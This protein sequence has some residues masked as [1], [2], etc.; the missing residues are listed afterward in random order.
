MSRHII[1]HTSRPHRRMSSRGRFTAPG[2]L[3]AAGLLAGIAVIGIPLESAQAS[4]RG[5]ST[6]HSDYA[7]DAA[8]SQG[9]ERHGRASARPRYAPAPTTTTPEPLS[10]DVVVP[11]PA[12]PMTEPVVEPVISVPGATVRSEVTGA[13]AVNAVLP[14]SEPLKTV[15]DVLVPAP[16]TATAALVAGFPTAISVAPDSQIRDSELNLQESAL[17]ARLTAA[18]S[19]GSEDIIAHFAAS[20]SALGLSGTPAVTTGGNTVQTFYRGND[21]VVV[22]VDSAVQGSQYSLVG[23]FSLPG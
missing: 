20:L 8:A 16:G 23:T 2:L 14:P 4:E 11:D 9:S 1:Q 21:S 3:A 7:H 15:L 5:C 6:P 10:P 19:L 13:E 18:S 12:E 22:T 17:I